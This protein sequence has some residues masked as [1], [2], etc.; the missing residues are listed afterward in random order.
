M[1]NTWLGKMKR[2]EEEGIGIGIGVKLK[3][4]MSKGKLQEL[5]KKVEIV[6]N[7]GNSNSE[8]IGGLIFEECLNGRHRARLVASHHGKGF[9]SHVSPFKYAKGWAL[10]SIKY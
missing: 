1:G 10:T 3:V 4:R 7:K 5:M 6:S 2:D 9:Q 8:L